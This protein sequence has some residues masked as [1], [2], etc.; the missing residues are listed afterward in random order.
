LIFYTEKQKAMTIEI[1]AFD[2]LFFRDGKPFTMG[3]DVWASGI[4]PPAPTVFYGMLQSACASENGITPK[5]IAEATN[6]LNIQSVYLK[7]DDQLLFP[8]PADLIVTIKDRKKISFLKMKENNLVSSLSAK[9]SPMLLYTD[10]SGKVKDYNGKAFLDTI[11][12]EDY[13]QG[14]KEISLIEE[15]ELIT[16]EP[17]VGI[18]KSLA[19]NQTDEGKLYRVGMIRP[20]VNNA[21]KKL[22]FVIE[23]TGI[24]LKNKSGF[25]KLGAENKAACYQSVVMDEIEPP[26]INNNLLKI[27]LATPAIFKSG[28]L[29]DFIIKKEYKGIKLEL[30]TY[31]M[32]KPIYVGGFDMANRKPKPMKRAVAAGSVY[33]LRSDNANELAKKLH[34]KSISDFD[35]T[36][37]GFGKALIGTVQN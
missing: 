1:N 30:L 37:L 25:L 2:T 35:T 12:F 31:A 21:D 13:L 7:S 26:E 11:N 23:F 36:R 5:A 14:R 34:G 15:T 20:E 9:Q 29:P 28:A 32:G 22:S 18:G 6:S 4:F 3:D 19:T 10:A 27:Y 17:K 33:Y 8:F 24:E 16:V